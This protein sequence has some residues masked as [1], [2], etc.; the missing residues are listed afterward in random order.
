MFHG[1]DNLLRETDIYKVCVPSSCDR[2]APP[3]NEEIKEKARSKI[4]SIREKFMFMMMCFIIE[5]NKWKKM[6]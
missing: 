6:K 3:V 1:R 5:D 2:V 4:C